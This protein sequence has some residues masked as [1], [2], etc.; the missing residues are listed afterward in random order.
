MK[1]PLLS[2]NHIRLRAMEPED[3]NILYEMENDTSL[4][5]FGCTA[6]PYSRST[7]KQYLET[8]QNDLFA[9]KQIRLMIERKIDCKVMGTIDLFDFV[10]IHSR[11]AVGIVLLA[12]FRKKGYATE[13][14]M[15]LCNYV[16]GYL[17]LNQLYAHIA[18][19]NQT[20][21]RLFSSC[22]FTE[23]GVLKQWLREGKE[24]KD[25]VMVQKVFL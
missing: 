12:S 22:G 25:A 8:S 16:S 3:L 24:Y 10:P 21:L 13:A 7:L 9:D 1:Q 15:L 4:W 17:C 19:D 20:C 11:A 14:L 2:D 23:C 5:K 6:S 18:V